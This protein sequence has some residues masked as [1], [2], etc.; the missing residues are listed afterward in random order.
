MF[1]SRDRDI[2]RLEEEVRRLQRLLQEVQ[3]RTANHIALLQQQLANK[4]QDIEVETFL[5]GEWFIEGTVHSCTAVVYAHVCMLET[6]G[7]VTI[8][9]GLWE[10][11][12]RAQ[13]LHKYIHQY[14]IIN[15][16]V[17][18]VSLLSFSGLY[19]RW[20]R[21]QMILMLCR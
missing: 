2:Q 12:N 6:P 4:S 21:R 13:V 15:N 7:Q 19:E 20:H 5:Y 1:A 9:A 11:Q 14:I 18:K 10:D 17:L 8:T 3:E 16:M